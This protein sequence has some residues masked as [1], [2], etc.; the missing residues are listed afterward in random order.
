MNERGPGMRHLTKP[1]QL[2]KKRFDLEWILPLEPELPTAVAL[3]DLECD[4][5]TRSRL[6][7]AAM[8]PRR[9]WTSGRRWPIAPNQR[10]RSHL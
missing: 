7:M 4:P 3:H 8:K 6:V 1:A 10:T 5:R 9:C 2:D